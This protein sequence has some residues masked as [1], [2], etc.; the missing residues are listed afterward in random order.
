MA[1]LA[2]SVGKLLERAAQQLGLLP[3]V[4]GQETVGVGDGDEGGLEGV[5]ERL[6]GTGG[7]GVS[8]LD[9]SELEE[10]LD[11]GGGNKASTAGSGDQLQ[12]LQVSL[13]ASFFFFFFFSSW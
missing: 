10:A 12:R 5:L 13:A 3:Q 1:L 7:G 4:G 6:G 9:T 2:E 11:S 8:V